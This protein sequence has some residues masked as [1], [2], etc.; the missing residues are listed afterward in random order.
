MSNIWCAISAHGLGHAAQMIPVLNALGTVFDD[1]HVILRTTVPSSIFQENL[2]V[3]WELQPVSQD[4]GCLQR[5]PLE[6]DIDGTWAAYEAFHENWNERVSQEAQAIDQA[7]VDLVISNISY[8]AI[9]SAFHA[10]CPAV[11]IASLSW[12]QVLKPYIEPSSSKH[13]EIYERIREEYAK[14]NALIRLHPGIDMPAFPSIIETGPSFP[15]ADAEIA[16]QDVRKVL[17][18]ASG[19]KL[20]LIAFGGIPLTAL[21]LEQMDACTG[22]HFLVGG[23]PLQSSSKRIHSND[24]LTF[25][26]R[27][28][29]KQA[30][31][32]MTK[33][34]YATITSAVHYGIPVVYVRRDNFADEQCLVDY[35][36]QYGRAVELSREDFESGTWEKALH[37]VLTLPPSLGL[38]PQPELEAVA[39]MLK[40]ISK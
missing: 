29:M 38:P 1:V 36:D 35:V 17:G 3:S 9:A 26:F 14:A 10:E 18:I 40:I 7:K 8:L 32:V 21:P 22:Y 16:T 33:P 11:A 24:A 6:I 20:V 23:I 4:I 27:E 39:E 34:G 30:D 5:G 19:E 25:P 37:E 28:V 13:Q 2:H 15:Y 12:D 31:V